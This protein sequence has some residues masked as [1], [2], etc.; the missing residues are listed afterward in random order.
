MTDVRPGP[1]ARALVSTR[2]LLQLGPA[3]GGGKESLQL[4]LPLFTRL[5]LS[6]HRPPEQVRPGG[7][8]AAGPLRNTA[9]AS[10]LP[11]TQA[12]SRRETD[13]TC[14]RFAQAL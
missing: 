14:L 7:S 13:E 9:F 2:Q 4:L 6:H 5:R 12:P 11:D 8:I 3:L 1:S 10:S